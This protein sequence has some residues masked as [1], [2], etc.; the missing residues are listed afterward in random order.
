MRF[1]KVLFV[2]CLFTLVLKYFPVYYYTTQ[3]ND[4]VLFE[5]EHT[6]TLSK[7][8][9][10]LFDQAE[11]FFIPLQAHDVKIAQ[12]GPDFKVE[13]DYEVPVNLYVYKHYLTFHAKARGILPDY[14]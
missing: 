2:G 5:T 6:K 1:L 8:R 12:N 11:E 7:L 14:R 9:Q 13:V 10:S 3:F 4:S